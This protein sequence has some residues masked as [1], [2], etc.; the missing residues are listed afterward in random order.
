M[1]RLYWKIFIWFWIAL[2]LLSLSI[3]WGVKVYLEQARPLSEQLPQA[4]VAAI[5]LAFERGDTRKARN[6]LRALNKEIRFPIF[7]VNEAGEDI[8]G[9]PLPRFVARLVRH[10]RKNSK[11][12]FVTEVHLPGGELYQVIA[13]KQQPF[14]PE[15]PPP[16][17]LALSITLVVSTLLC[18]WL[19]RYLTAPIARLRDATHRLASGE[20]SVRVGDLR[21]R[22]DEIADLAGDFDRMADKSQE[23]L[24]GRQQLLRDISHELR[25]PL[26]RLQVALALARRQ[27]PG[28]LDRIERDLLRLEE[29]IGEVLAL[30]RLEASPDIR[31]DETVPLS[32]LIDEI[33][34]DTRLEADQKPCALNA[35]VEPGISLQGNAELLR[36]AI[37]NIVRNAIK[38]TA[39]H[40]TVMLALTADERDIHVQVGDRGPG[41]TP[42]ELT[43]IFDPFVRLDSARERHTGGY[44]LGLAIARKAVELHGGVILA[45]NRDDGLG[46]CIEIT[47]PR[48]RRG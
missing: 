42:G 18:L 25:S 48:Q 17:W 47:L 40:S 12:L 3:G 27:G 10:E 7:V 37:E 22:K 13:P 35:Q 32:A 26:A 20:L 39:E 43:A 14:P 23:L 30:S 15:S 45:R 38:Y 8:L 33:V 24:H 46:L 4:Q 5:S 21:G 34:G 29:L 2:A 31:L 44:G 28:A 41:V 19:A 11:Y 16:R 36:R 9:R 1:N 6:L